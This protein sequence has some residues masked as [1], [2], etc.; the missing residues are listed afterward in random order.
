MDS[1]KQYHCFP[2]MLHRHITY[3]AA[4]MAPELFGGKKVIVLLAYDMQIAARSE[5]A[6]GSISSAALRVARH[7]EAFSR[8]KRN[9][10]MHSLYGNWFTTREWWNHANNGLIVFKV[11]DYL[12]YFEASSVGE[13][14]IMSLSLTRVLLQS[15]IDVYGK[16]LPPQ[17]VGRDAAALLLIHFH[18]Q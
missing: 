1:S 18:I 4:Y 2:K 8:K 7:L 12:T 9:R 11:S 14:R 17:G 3:P 15:C 6:T 16:R 5:A 13:D 10:L